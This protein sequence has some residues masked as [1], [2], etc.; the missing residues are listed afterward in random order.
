MYAWFC[1]PVIRIQNVK[2]SK[3]WYVLIKCKKK[4][5]QEIS[6]NNVNG[7]NYT[8]SITWTRYINPPR[9]LLKVV[10]KSTNGST[11]DYELN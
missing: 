8:K 6:K 11:S 9:I 7:A 2:R 3:E 1:P 10:L 4:E 5:K